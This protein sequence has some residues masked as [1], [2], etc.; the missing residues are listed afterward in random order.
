MQIMVRKS[1]GAVYHWEAET[2]TS[3][4]AQWKIERKDGT[5]VLVPFTGT[6]YVV[7]TQ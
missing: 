1:G 2:V 7:I 4:G 5:V 3:E 6:D